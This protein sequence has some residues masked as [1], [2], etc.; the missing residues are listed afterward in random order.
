MPEAVPG[1][2][3]GCVIANF[4]SELGALDI[5]FGSLATLIAAV[6]SRRSPNIY[7]AAFWPVL[8]NMII[9]SLLLNYVIGAPL[10][11]T[12]IYIAVGEAIACYV[13]GVPLMKLLEKR[14]IIMRH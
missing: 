14:N 10:I 3:V 6:L 13:I 11:I 1:L 8:S 7:V 12:G 9:I 5:I 2:L 4:Y